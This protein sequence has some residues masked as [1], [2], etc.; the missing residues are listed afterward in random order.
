MIT[1]RIVDEYGEPIS[2]VQV[3]AVR[4]DVANGRRRLFPGR[5][6]STGDLGEFR[7][8]GVQPTD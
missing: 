1:G 7:L 8:F 4:Q 6:P 5:F 2:R 3:A